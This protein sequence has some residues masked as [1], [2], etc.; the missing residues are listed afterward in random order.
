M[1]RLFFSLGLLIAMNHCQFSHHKIIIH[2]DLKG[3]PPRPSYFKQ[4]LTTISDVGADG[5]L[6]EWEDM[7]P[8]EGALGEI[9]NGYSYTHDE[10][11]DILRHAES[12]KLS[13]IPLVQTIGHLEWI[14]KI[15]N[16]VGFREH[17]D[18]PLVACIGDD[19]VVELILDSL[20]QVMKLHSEVGMPY[21]HI[22]A[23]EAYIMG[24]C[25]ADL[26]ILPNYANNKKR[27]V[28]D[29]VKK[30]AKNITLQYPQTKVLIWH[31]EF[32]NVN[33][34][35]VKQYE[36][37]RLVTPVVW[38][39]QP[40]LAT[41]LPKY[42]WKQLVRS[43]SSVWGASAFK[44]GNGP[45]RYWNYVEHYMKNNKAWYQQALEHS[46][47]IKFQG[48]IITGWQR[49]HHFAPL[50]ELFPVSMAS[51]AIN[52]K[53]IK[54]FTLSEDDLSGILH[55]LKCPNGTT[56]SHLK[57]GQDQCRFSG[58]KVRNAIRDFMLIKQQHD[59]AMIFEEAEYLQPYQMQMNFSCSYG[60]RN[61]EIMY[62]K[63]LQRLD[64]MIDW[65]RSSLQELFYEDVY[66]EFMVDYI[67]P[68]YSELESKLRSVRAINS[69]TVYPPRPW[70]PSEGTLG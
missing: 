33:D 61:F 16:F 31:D 30:V 49:F 32:K 63:Y 69:R 56:I 66:F 29:Y 35:L 70:F 42:K 22:G 45:N 12:L 1:R 8:Y 59:N 13:V 23:D 67:E 25:P 44:G 68:F 55:A 58:H 43:F 6:I 15:K 27:L 24:E 40:D 19:K 54:H 7:F 2:I 18:Y 41:K 39:Y 14:L 11:L 48:F 28:F 62:K 9:K 17:P 64:E 51:L 10:A 60:I 37:D 65:L 26:R 47:L 52:V 34:T 57:R 21:V 5:V 36:L 4:L 46:D 38:Y 20:N 50:C 3:A 53:L